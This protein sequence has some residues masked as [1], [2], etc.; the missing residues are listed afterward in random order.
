MKIKIMIFLIITSVS[1]LVLL[2]L[3]EYEKQKDGVLFKIQNKW[4]G[5]KVCLNSNLHRRNC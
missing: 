4:Y 2:R 3:F 5:S 1:L